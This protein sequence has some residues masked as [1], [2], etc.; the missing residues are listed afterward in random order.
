V[1]PVAVLPNRTLAGFFVGRYG[2][3]STIQYSE[4]I[5]IC[6]LV[7]AAGRYGFW[8]SHI[9]VDDE[10][11]CAGGRQFWGLPKVV[12][13]F[14]WSDRGVAVSRNGK[15]LLEVSW[16]WPLPMIPV[17]GRV[18]VLSE[19]QDG[20]IRFKGV[21]NASARL[22]RARWRSQGE[23][24]KLGIRPFISVCLPKLRLKAGEPHLL[25]DI[26]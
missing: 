8:A 25:V 14:D 24:G 10:V 15:A 16:R 6:G 17:Y 21:A 1:E 20:L 9:Y 11:S 2:P 18:P 23:L 26:A 19:R 7:R 5:A 22:V 13:A 12:A 4:M 3:G